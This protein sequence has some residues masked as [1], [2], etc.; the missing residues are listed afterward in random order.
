MTGFYSW[1]QTAGTN[2]SSEGAINWSEGQ[3]PSSVNDSARSMMA[4]LAKFR[5]DTNGSI[6]VGGTSSAY[7]VST[8]QVFTST[9]VMNNAVV[10][11][12]ITPTNVAGATLNVDGLGAFPLVTAVG[13]PIPAG[14]LV[15][16][17]IYEVTFVNSA[18]VWKLRN[19]F[20][21]PYNVPIG[22]LMD[23]IGPTVPSSNFAF[24][25][26]QAISRTTYAT[27][28]ALIGTT[29]GT[30]DG[31]TT[32]NVP[33]LTGRVVAMKEAT[34]TRLTTAGGG[35]DGGT[36]GAVG[37]IQNVSLVANQIPT[38]TATNASQ[39][40]SVTSTRSTLN[41]AVSGG[42]IQTGGVLPGPAAANGETFNQM[43]S[44]GNNSISATY[45]NGSQVAVK[46]VP[47]TIVLNKILRIL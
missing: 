10:S 14:A 25:I 47:P 8:S 5:D 13:A 6:L 18:S 21:N 7:T 27:L 2:A 39:A 34:A 24:P 20:Q 41:S 19:F 11:F 1:S 23:Y 46:N 38:I 45:T 32:F 9:T 12:T 15:D 17:T 36:L 22:G 26:G 44:S 33:D 3:A 29:Y 31:S 16:G 40:I 37:G 30:G 35:V 28:F 42:S 4:S 43:V